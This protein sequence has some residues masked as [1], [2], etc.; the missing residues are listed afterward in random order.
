MFSFPFVPRRR[1][2]SC[3][4]E[5]LEG[6]KYEGSLVPVLPGAR[7]GS[8]FKDIMQCLMLGIKLSFN[9]LVPGG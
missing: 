6:V 7:N 5:W 8:E 1:G 3:K 2:R 9:S 4:T